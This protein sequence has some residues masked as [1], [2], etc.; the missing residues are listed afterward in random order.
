[1]TP[2][3]VTPRRRSLSARLLAA[4]VAL[5]ALVCL[6]IGLITH[7]AMRSTLYAQ[8]DEQLAFASER[9]S[10]FGGRGDGSDPLNAP[11]QASGTLNARLIGNT[12]Q[13]GGVLDSET[14][15]RRD[16]SDFTQDDADAIAAV[17]PGASPVDIRLSFGEYRLMA[18]SVDPGAGSGWTLITGL[19][20]RPAENTLASLSWTMLLV[21]GAGVAATGLIGSLIIQRSLRP[22]ERVSAVAGSVATLPLDAGEV[23]LAHRVS[24]ADSEP[25]TEAGNVGHALN[26]LLDNVESAL[27]ARQASEEKM[28]RF[29]ADASHELRTPLASVRGYSEL[30]SATEHLSPDGQRSL[31]RIVEQSRR[32]GSLVENLLLLARLDEG[33]RPTP[34]EVDL[35]LLVAEAARDFRVT[36][37]EHQWRL[38]LPSVPLVV[39]GD[40]GQLARVLNN[41]LSNAHKHTPEG[42]VVEATLAREADGRRAVLTVADS[43]EGIDP[44]FLPKVFSR[45][46]RADAARSGDD[47]TTGL[48][49]PI[50]K[51]I[52]EAH[53]GD[54]SVASEPGRTEFRV[55]L[56]LTTPSQPREVDISSGS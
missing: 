49:L 14:G 34:G 3:A 46:T 10:A 39:H 20:L 13:I 53:G 18:V 55:T 45:F 27:E 41:L 31:D 37:P 11:G 15:D 38:D 32:M 50:V 8:V 22:L 2:G 40:A 1:M 47:E 48:G 24:P 6:V 36:A 33:H 26:A 42:T 51:A 16:I 21:S 4:V 19:P 35:T 25:G 7:T 23:R 5:L 52:V 44:E 54:I 17:T 9:A 28:R 29:V 56:P 30:V 12:L 43:G